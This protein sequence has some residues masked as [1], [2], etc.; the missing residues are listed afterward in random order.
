MNR[1]NVRACCHYKVPSPSGEE[2]RSLR[3]NAQNIIPGVHSLSFYN[4]LNIHPNQDH[5]LSGDVLLLGDAI[6]VAMTDGKADE[7][8]PGAV[9]YIFEGKGNDDTIYH[10]VC[11][12]TFANINGDWMYDPNEPTTVIQLRA[13]IRMM[14]VCRSACE[15]NCINAAPY[16][17]ETLHGVHLKGIWSYDEQTGTWCQG[18]SRQ[19]NPHRWTMMQR[20]NLVNKLIEREQREKQLEREAQVLRAEAVAARQSMYEAE[21]QADILKEQNAELDDQL[22]DHEA[23]FKEYLP[24]LKETGR[25]KRKVQLLKNKLQT[26][27]TQLNT[28]S[29][30]LECLQTKFRALG[31]IINGNEYNATDEDYESMQ[32]ALYKVSCP[33]MGP[34]DNRMTDKSSSALTKPDP[35]AQNQ[36]IARRSTQND[37]AAPNQRQM[38]DKNERKVGEKAKINQIDRSGVAGPLKRRRI[39]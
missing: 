39:D 29:E 34:S 26:V 18:F 15:A 16:G 1:D 3:R 24:D 28:K 35:K 17:S 14:A 36:P 38:H 32:A 9:Q 11:F 25:L 37:D 19:S 12:R 2:I 27:Q 6:G 10:F 31:G 23:H 4:I 22:N 20:V 30:K 7:L 21:E 33:N 5:P 13:I 8:A